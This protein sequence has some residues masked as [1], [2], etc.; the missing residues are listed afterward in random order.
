LGDDVL[1]DQLHNLADRDANADCRELVF[2]RMQELSDHPDVAEVVNRLDIDADY[3]MNPPDATNPADVEQGENDQEVNEYKNS[4]PGETDQEELRPVEEDILESIRR[5]AGLKENVTLDESGHTF[6]H[7]LNTYK[8]DVK[9]FE[10]TGEMTDALYDVLY[11]YYFDDMPYGTKKG[12]DGDP[13]EWIGDRFAKDIGLNEGELGTA[14]GAGIGGAVGGIPGAAL[15]GVAGH[16]LT[17]GE[18]TDEGWKGQLAG[19]TVGAIGGELAGAAVGGPIGALAGGAL[20]GT[21]GQMIGDKLG[22]ANE[23]T[24][25]YAPEVTDEE[26]YGLNPIP[27][28][29]EDDSVHSVDGGMSNSLLQDDG[30]CNMSEAGQMC[31][32]HGIQ[33]CWGAP[34]QSAVPGIVPTLETVELPDLGLVRMQQLAGFMIR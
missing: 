13:Y 23:N 32:V 10:A 4:A 16:Y 31:P 1:F 18:E 17:N 20:G 11:D 9:D 30:V 14:V 6:Q 33:E 26:G 21:A 25:D 2:L 22:G 24:M 12:R 3:A 19:G 34:V 7:I 28:A 15:G 5:A 8:R 27:T 29:M